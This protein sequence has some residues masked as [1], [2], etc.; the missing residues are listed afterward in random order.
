MK[1]KDTD[2]NKTVT[3]FPGGIPAWMTEE[4]GLNMTLDELRGTLDRLGKKKDY[5]S[6]SKKD[7]L[8]SLLPPDFIANRKEYSKAFTEAMRREAVD[9]VASLKGWDLGDFH[10]EL[11]GDQ[12]RDAINQAREQRHLR[13]AEGMKLRGA[14]SV[15]KKEPSDSRFV[16][17]PSPHTYQRG[18][19]DKPDVVVVVTPDKAAIHLLRI[20]DEAKGLSPM[21]DRL[22]AAV[23]ASLHTGADKVTVISAYPGLNPVEETHSGQGFAAVCQQVARNILLLESTVG[24]LLGELESAG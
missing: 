22:M 14:S 6:K 15:A 23:H 12:D 5:T 19:P 2:S 8:I 9:I 17:A 16:L 20:L 11:M 1:T 21:P 24:V 10:H 4:P 3:L 18:A 7:D 13:I